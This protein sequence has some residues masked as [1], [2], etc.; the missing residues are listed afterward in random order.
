M[1]NFIEVGKTEEEQA[2]QIKKW[3]K[4]NALQIVIGVALGVSGIW[5][6]NYYNI[7]QQ[8]QAIQARSY[9]L[10]VVDNPSNIQ[11]LNALKE[12]HAD[13]SYAQQ[14]DLILAKQAVSKGDYQGALTYLHPLASSKNEFI[15]HV[16]KLRIANLHLEMG[17]PD[18]A[19]SILKGNTN[20]EFNALYNYIKGDAYFTKNDLIAAKKYYQLA[21][22]QLPD[23]S[24]FKNLIKVKLNDIN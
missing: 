22:S 17:N 23:S 16:A 13:S 8:K 2:E 24:R 19:L 5:G 12:Q 3:I 14:A 18:Q 15:M 4:E 11:A 1:K 7:Q 21:F 6:V 10:S 20:K 9:Y